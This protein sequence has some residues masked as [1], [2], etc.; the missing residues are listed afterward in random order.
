MKVAK[1]VG[2]IAFFTSVLLI[3]FFSI[4]VLKPFYRYEYNVHKTE[5]SF[6][7]LSE[8]E[9]IN[10]SMQII[11]YFF[12]KT[13]PISITDK[14]GKVDNYFT[15]REVIHMKDV[16]NL[17]RLSLILMAL[18]S[19]IFVLIL[20]YTE[21]KKSFLKHSSFVSILVILLFITAAF[22]N[23]DKVF[24]IFHK[25]FFRNDFWLLPENSKLIEMFPEV[26]FYDFAKL[27]FF[28]FVGVNAMIYFVST[29][30]SRS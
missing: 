11:S 25:I 2:S 18:C 8:S 30:F 7:G 22:L 23:F 9:Y 27:W 12:T 28:I 1:T 3:V 15:M 4:L 17:V 24:I 19:I 29:Y 20:I 26:F 21:D 16:K 5:I 13:E 14:N 10:Y 6:S